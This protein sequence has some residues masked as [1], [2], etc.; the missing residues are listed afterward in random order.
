MASALTD[1]MSRNCA[2]IALTNIHHNLMLQLP[3]YHVNLDSPSIEERFIQMLNNELRWYSTHMLVDLDRMDNCSLYQ[4]TEDELITIR[5]YPLHQYLTEQYKERYGCDS[6]SIK[7]CY[8]D[9]QSKH[10]N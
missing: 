6:I 3:Y 9:W 4:V 2:D 8:Q 5:T 7:D 1:I 10:S